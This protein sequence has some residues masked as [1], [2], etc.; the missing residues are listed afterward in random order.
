M[1][2]KAIRSYAC[3]DRHQLRIVG[4]DERDELRLISNDLT[5]ITAIFGSCALPQ[6]PLG[7]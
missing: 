5:V 4:I 6:H 2:E 1:I 7:Q 3:G